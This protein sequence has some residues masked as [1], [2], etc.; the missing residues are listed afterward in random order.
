V[1]ER[2][3]FDPREGGVMEGLEK[4]V[5]GIGAAIDWVEAP[6][7]EIS[8]TELRERVRDGRSIRYRTPEAVRRYIEARGLYK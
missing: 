5:P 4:Q 7:M 6:L 1:I 3:N 8:S 2:P